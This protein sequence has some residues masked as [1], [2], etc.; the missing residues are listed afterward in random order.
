[1]ARRGRLP[2]G[3]LSDPSRRH[4]SRPVANAVPPSCHFRPPHELA[5]G[6]L[7]DAIS[8]L[9]RQEVPETILEARALG[10]HVPQVIGPDVVRDGGRVSLEIG[11]AVLVGAAQLVPYPGEDIVIQ[12]DRIDVVAP[13]FVLGQRHA[14]L[15][16]KNHPDDRDNAG[17]HFVVGNGGHLAPVGRRSGSL[18]AGHRRGER[19][20]SARASNFA[21]NARRLYGKGRAATGPQGI[22]S[23]PG[24]HD[25]AGTT[26]VRPYGK[27][28]T[29]GQNSFFRS[30]SGKTNAGFT[31]PSSSWHR[32]PRRR[33]MTNPIG[34]SFR[35]GSGH[36]VGSW[37]LAAAVWAF[38]LASAT[39]LALAQHAPGQAECQAKA[40]Q[41]KATLD[42]NH[43]QRD[44]QI[45]NQRNDEIKRCGTDT[46]CRNAVSAKAA[47]LT[48]DN[49]QQFY[50]ATSQA[51]GQLMECNLVPQSPK[52][53]ETFSS[54]NPPA[55][56]GPAAPGTSG[57]P[58]PLQGGLKDENRTSP[59]KVY[60]PVEGGGRY[61]YQAVPQS[62][63]MRGGATTGSAPGPGAAQSTGLPHMTGEGIYSRN[64]QR[65]PV[66][67][68][69]FAGWKLNQYI[70]GD[71]RKKT[72]DSPWNLI[73]G[74][75]IGPHTVHVTAVTWLGSGKREPVDIT[76]QMNCVEIGCK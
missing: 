37:R 68:E 44:M 38:G 76:V 49:N 59:P 19:A 22:V 52:L 65:I 40:R 56:G 54:N 47:Q 66:Y 73:E 63:P 26:G 74:K 18:N 69:V 25:A 67:V 12:L 16:P 41:L 46:N 57:R 17:E 7:P 34:K 50:K 61:P 15:V 51:Q 14:G 1:M 75:I 11:D 32:L 62:Q 13:G 28:S 43:K 33:R 24:A 20:I 31:S 53:D 10:I 36:P 42:L 39:P 71:P 3:S 2:D 29:T 48:L 27:S 21:E 70:S 55:P 4:A 60:K 72:P 23:S 9:M 35:F 58:A 30:E 64:N 8:R 6:R 5:L 45:A